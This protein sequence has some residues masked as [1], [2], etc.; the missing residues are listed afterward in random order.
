VFKHFTFALLTVLSLAAT[1]VHALPIENADAF[2]DGDQLAAYDPST[3]ITW[4]DFGVNNGRSFN[5][6]IDALGSVYE[7]WR[8]PTETEVRDLWSK[9]SANISDSNYEIFSLFGANKVPSKDF[10]PYLCYGSFIDENGF[11]AHGSFVE[12]GRT[13]NPFGSEKY[14]SDGIV[15]GDVYSD[16]STKYD[17][18]DPFFDQSGT[19]EISTLL[20]RNTN[21]SVS[22]PSSLILLIMG[23]LSLGIFRRKLRH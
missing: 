18:S 10:L 19:F 16:T 17:H 6:V 11:I 14:F 13:R 22:E 2:A 15:K 12:S 7:G 20:V 21:V 8:L 5:S 3:G 1:N 9:L 4:M 23:V